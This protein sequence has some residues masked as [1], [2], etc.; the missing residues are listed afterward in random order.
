MFSGSGGFLRSG[1]RFE[2]HPDSV[3]VVL[4]DVLLGL[5]RNLVEL[6]LAAVSHVSGSHGHSGVQSRTRTELCR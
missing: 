3:P 6:A 1:I 2:S 5:D 4:G